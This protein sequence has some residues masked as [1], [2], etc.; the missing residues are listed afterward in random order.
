MDDYSLNPFEYAADRD[1][2]DSYA[3]GGVQDAARP[4]TRPP[5]KGKGKDKGK[6]GGVEKTGEVEAEGSGKGLPKLSKVS[7]RPNNLP[8][9]PVKRDAIVDAFKWAW[10]AYERD[11]MGFDEYHPLSKRGSNLG[12]GGIGYTVVDALDT[13]LLMGTNKGEPLEGEYGRARKWVEEELS[14]NRVGYYSTFE[15][16]IRVLGGLLSAYYLTGDALYLRHAAD[17]GDRILPAF[18]KGEHNGESGGAGLP[19]AS[20]NLGARSASPG[21]VSISEATTLQLEFKY[22]AEATGRI[23]FWRKAERVMEV[24]NRAR[25]PSGGKNGAGGLAPIGM[26]CVGNGQFTRSTIRMGSNGDSYYEYLLKQYLQT[27]RTEPVYLQMYADSMTGVHEHMVWKSANQKLTFLAELQPRGDGSVD[28]WRSDFTPD[29]KQ[30]HLACFLAGSLMLGATTAHALDP[31]AQKRAPTPKGGRGRGVSRPPK[32]DELTA[33]GRRDWETGVAYLDGC[34][35]TLGTETGLSPEGVRFRTPEDPVEER[36]WYIPGWCVEGKANPP[37]DARYML[38]PEIAESVFL[39]YRLTGDARYRAFAW[40]IFSAIERHC[41]LP[42]GGYAT[43]LDVD[44]V[45]VVWA[46]KQETFFLSE[47]LKYLFLTFA[48]ENVLDLNADEFVHQA[49]PLPIFNPTIKPSF[50][51]YST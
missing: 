22:L 39:A 19:A 32:M 2:S 18:G 47:T 11:A 37:Y 46:D 34:L 14:F 16:T 3:E 20:V 24:V 38:R 43:V 48:D 30:E 17:L 25:L 40:D 28:G 10:S 15:T 1:Y 35:D 36:D 4:P 9:D 8:A 51:K 31:A 5:S 21:A 49:H 29:P 12:G 44:R 7:S 23:V 50:I 42:G 27:N 41:R 33:A 13:M 45:P 26:K 6:D